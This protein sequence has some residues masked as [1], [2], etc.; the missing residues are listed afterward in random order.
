MDRDRGMATF[1]LAA[2]PMASALIHPHLAAVAAVWAHW[3]GHDGFHAGAFLTDGGVWG[4]LGEKGSG[5]SSILAALAKRGVPIVCDD[6]LV[7]ADRTA[8]AGPRSID[9]RADA[10]EQLGIGEPLGVIGERERWRV[11]LGPIEPEL[12][13]RGWIALGWSQQP[14]IRP[15]EGAGRLRQLLANR[16]LLVP[17]RSPSSVFDLAELPFFE[18]SRPRRWD[19][20]YG[21]L[22]DLLGAISG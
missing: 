22:G 6:V 9:L 17:P 11:G 7:L 10:A 16:A 21:A 20:M 14:M 19:T 18:F 12:P 1:T 8:F 5:K 4:V 2:E 3:A 15:L 13:F